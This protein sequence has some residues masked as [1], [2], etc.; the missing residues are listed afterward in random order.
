MTATTTTGKSLYQST[1][2][3]SGGSVLGIVMGTTCVVDDSEHSGRIMSA[4][5]GADP[6]FRVRWK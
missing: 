6:Q 1:K 2:R 5:L 4:V 3:V